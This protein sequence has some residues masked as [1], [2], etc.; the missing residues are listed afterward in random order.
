MANQRNP[1]GPVA[2][3]ELRTTATTADQLIASF[4]CT[5]LFAQSWDNAMLKVEASV[6]SFTEAGGANYGG[7]IEIV[8]G[9]SRRAGV[10]FVEGIR[11]PNN[12][13]NGIVSGGVT[14]MTV[15]ANADNKTVE[16]KITPRAGNIRHYCTVRAMA[17]QYQ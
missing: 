7:L 17:W 16:I 5:A 3:A 14:S 9:V 15:V 8:A 4:D 6:L 2:T 12:D 10:L 1:E 13:A 11:A